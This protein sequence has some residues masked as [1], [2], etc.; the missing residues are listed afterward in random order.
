VAG[1]VARMSER[2]DLT[3]IGVIENMAYYE[4][5]GKRDYIF[6]KEGGRHLAERLGV[7]LLAQIPLATLIREG[8]D[9]GQPAA[10]EPARGGGDG[11]RPV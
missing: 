6:G 9:T 2:T 7:P 4:V 10:L 11:I 1:R 8:S 3:V 5:D